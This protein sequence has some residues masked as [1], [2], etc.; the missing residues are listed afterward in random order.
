MIW[1]YPKVLWAL[2]ILPF[3]VGLM[4]LAYRKRRAAA[5]RFSDSAMMPRLMPHLGAGRLWVK[6]T[7]IVLGL[8]CV[9]LALARP[10]Y[11]EYFEQVGKH[12]VDM[13]VLMDTSRSMLAE[14]IA[15]NRLDRAKAD[16][17]D[18][19]AELPGERVGLIAFAGKPVVKVPLT[20]DQGFFCHMLDGLHT[21]SAPRGGTL[22]GDAIRKGLECMPQ[23]ENR[24]QVMLLITD[25]EDHDSFPYE[26]AKVAAQRGVK[27]FT[28]GL[29]DADEGTRVPIRGEDGKLHYLK[30]DGQEVWSKMDKQLL[31]KIAKDS[32]GAYIP[33]G[34]K[35]YDLGKIYQD[36]LA[37]LTHGDLETQKRKRYHDRFQWFL[38]FAVVFLLADM[39]IPVH[40]RS[41]HLPSQ[42]E[43]YFRNPPKR[44]AERDAFWGNKQRGGVSD[45]GNPP[46][47]SRVLPERI[48]TP[49]PAPEPVAVGSGQESH[50]DRE[51]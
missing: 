39:V 44:S 2:W 5:E 49:E 42:P 35:A 1:E 14:D 6:G 31:E 28:V 40:R 47:T 51:N 21:R 15:P 9:I 11:G 16:V 29:G 32:G 36:H 23:R 8:A 48:E 3:V 26:A 4:V 33:A 43:T 25:G 17:H 12:G 37:A 41:N 13:F 38:C 45:G 34:T 10:R 30:H 24:D 7:L 18:L 50:T 20:T 22:I 46:L 27:I 19:L